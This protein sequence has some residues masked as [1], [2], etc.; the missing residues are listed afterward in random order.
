MT[1]GHRNNFKIVS[2][3][4]LCP[5]AGYDKGADGKPVINKEEA[6]IVR[7]IYSKFIEG[8]TAYEIARLLTSNHITSLVVK[9]MGYNNSRVHLN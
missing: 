8:L 2:L 1:W 6:E 5:L 9:K 7:F 3:H 4:F